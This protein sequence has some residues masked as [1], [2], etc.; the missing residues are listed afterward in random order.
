M[1]HRLASKCLT[2]LGKALRCMASASQP[3]AYQELTNILITRPHRTV[4]ASCFRTA[5]SLDETDDTSG[6]GRLSLKTPLIR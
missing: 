5:L 4:T 1:F 2:D 3:A 6:V